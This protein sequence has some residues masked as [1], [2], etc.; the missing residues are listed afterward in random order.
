MGGTS[1]QVAHRG[2]NFEVGHNNV[3][4]LSSGQWPGIGARI[5]LNPNIV[6]LFLRW[7]T[8]PW[9]MPKPIKIPSLN[10][11]LLHFQQTK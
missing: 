1:L 3:A 4:H 6:A 11:F 8:I 2:P 5:L 9:P 10:F 7:A